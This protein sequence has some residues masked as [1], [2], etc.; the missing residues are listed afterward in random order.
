[1]ERALIIGAGGWGREVLEQMRGD[2]G[3]GKDWLIGGFLDSRTNI[4]DSYDIDTSI[5][6]DPMNYV[7]QVN[8]VFICAMGNPHDRYRY[9]Q[10][11]LEK[12]GRFIPI[13]TDIRLGR[14]VRFGQGCFF[15]LLVQS[16]PDVQIGDFVTIHAQSM[17]GHDVLIGNYVHV[18]AMAF[19]GGNVQIGDFVT[20]H[21]RATLMPGV[22]VGNNAVIGAGA[23][24]LKDVPA[25]TSVFGNPAKTVFHKDV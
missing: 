1:M 12:G 15:G 19:M 9:S 16:G 24:V 6:G 25:G 21:P 13:C 20:I 5:V 2:A 17:I 7:P 18:G 8:D 10:P 11:I 22:K 4:L 3:H 14:R 23:V